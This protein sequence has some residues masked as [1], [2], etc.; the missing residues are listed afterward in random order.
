MKNILSLALI[1]A[2]L[3]SVAQTDKELA[4]KS[5][6]QAIIKSHIGFLAS[7][8]LK[9][10]DTPSEGLKIA[11]KYIESRFLEYGVE[12]AP[13]MESFMQPVPMKKIMPRKIGVVKVGKTELELEKDLVIIEGYKSIFDQPFHFA[14]YGLPDQLT[15]EDIKG[16]VVF[17]LC[18]DGESQSP[19]EWFTLSSEKRDRVKELGGLAL[20]E[21]YSS[22]Q[23][24]WN[25]L[26]RYLSRERVAIDEGD[27]EGGITHIW[28]NRSADDASFLDSK[29]PAS[30]LVGDMENEKFVSQNVVGYVEGTDPKLKDEIIVYSAHYDHVGIGQADANGDSIYNGSR[31]NAV[32]TVTVLSA[33]KSIAQ[34]PTKRSALF[35]LF[36]GEEKGLLGSKYFVDNSPVELSKMV[37]C[38][39]S[40]N[41]GYNDTSKATIIGLNRTTA[42]DMIVEACK[43]FGLEATDDPA[44][45]QGLFDRS[46][47]VRFA[48]KGIPAP[49][50]GMG[51]TAFD[52]EITKYYHQPAD[53]PNTLD[54]AYLEK[55]FRSYVYACR[56]IG[57]AKKAPFWVKG[58]KY[59][60]AGKTL[61]K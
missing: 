13:G 27:D 18:G 52:D 55:F 40:D 14:E 24:P 23:I 56:M 1:T 7:D 30:I 57:N 11:A 61:Y 2:S 45:E 42:N 39:N 41:G 29:R 5:T 32:G 37:Y 60:D 46:D 59:Y 44:P 3:L 16:K 53:N 49:T 43:A 20:V 10:R 47:N 26:V 54:Y 17:A 48:V 38:F 58:D 28:L 34:N 4:E 33:A 51:F 12:M 19:Q 31:D 9:G 35:V 50:F 21:L 22:T 36:T 6:N 25:F 15:E 8:E